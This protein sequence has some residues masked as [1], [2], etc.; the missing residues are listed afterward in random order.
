MRFIKTKII[1]NITFL[2]SQNF[3][4]PCDVTQKLHRETNFKSLY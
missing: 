1:L 4:S 2:I 3:K